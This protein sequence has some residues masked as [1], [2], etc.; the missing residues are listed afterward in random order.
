MLYIKLKVFYVL[1]VCVCVCVL[2]FFTLYKFALLNQ[3]EPNFAHISPL[4]GKRP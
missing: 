2:F 3:S 4:V 1:F